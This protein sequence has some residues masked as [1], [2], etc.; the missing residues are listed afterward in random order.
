MGAPAEEVARPLSQHEIEPLAGGQ[1]LLRA[2][3][4]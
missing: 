3:R 2:R 1:K 4:Q